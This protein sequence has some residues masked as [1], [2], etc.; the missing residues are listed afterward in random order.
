M[1]RTLIVPPRTAGVYSIVNLNSGRIYIGG[2]VCLMTR[3]RGHRFDL[4]HG[5]S[6]VRKMQKDFDE[7][8]DSLEFS[9]VEL[10]SQQ[11]LRQREQFWINFYKACDP[12]LGYNRSMSATKSEGFKWTDEQR[13][14]KSLIHKGVPKPTHR[15]PIIQLSIGGNEI[16][17]FESNFAA[18]RELGFSRPN[19][20]IVSVCRGKQSTAYGYRWAYA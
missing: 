12:R 18:S 3:F 20:N 14:L 13:K 10:V 2:T 11:E 16:K 15:K 9:I 5:Q 4:S 19:G 1:R 7:A 17:R 8:P 6:R